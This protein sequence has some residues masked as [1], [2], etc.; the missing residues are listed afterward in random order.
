MNSTKMTNGDYYLEDT[1]LRD[2]GYPQSDTEEKDD[3]LAY[4]IYFLN[5]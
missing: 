4:K 1:S 2:G 3:R 5:V